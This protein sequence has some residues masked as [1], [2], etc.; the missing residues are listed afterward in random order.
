MRNPW[1]SFLLYITLHCTARYDKPGSFFLLYERDDE[2]LSSGN[3]LFSPPDFFFFYISTS[4]HR[5][6]E[7]KIC[8]LVLHF[9]VQCLLLG[10][11]KDLLVYTFFLRKQKRVSRRGL[12]IFLVS[13]LACL[14][15]FYLLL[16]LS[17]ME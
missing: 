7:R 13:L 14:L 1:H 12:L 4:D 8:T 3:I 15:A 11:R 2:V 10:E 17:W 5:S 16:Y 9:L 6:G